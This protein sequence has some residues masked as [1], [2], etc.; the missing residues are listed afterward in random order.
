MC[1]EHEQMPS[2]RTTRDKI[3]LKNFYLLTTTYCLLLTTQSVL[4]THR[5]LQ[6]G[7]PATKLTW[8]IDGQNLNSNHTLP[9]MPSNYTKDGWNMRPSMLTFH[10]ACTVGGNHSFFL[11][12]I[13]GARSNN[14][15][16]PELSLVH[17]DRDKTCR[18]TDVW[19]VRMHWYPCQFFKL[20]LSRVVRLEG[21]GACSTYFE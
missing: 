10:R 6:D 15:A 12:N 20:I 3:N 4:N 1:V 5:C 14:C 2:R 7:Q 9:T 13:G 19:C 16:K 11:F 18:E 8:K 21:I 17:A